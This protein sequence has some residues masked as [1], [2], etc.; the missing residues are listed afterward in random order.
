MSLINC[1]ISICICVVIEGYGVFNWPDGGRYEGNYVNE[2]KEGFGV[3]YWSEG[4]IYEGGWK[5]G[6]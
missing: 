2:K 3:F 5:N 4:R 6:K 1:P